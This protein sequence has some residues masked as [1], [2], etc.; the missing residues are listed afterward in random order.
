MS[1]NDEGRG[2]KPSQAGEGERRRGA[3]LR[4]APLRCA[5]G[6]STP[7]GPPPARLPVGKS[8]CR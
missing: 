2:G 5:P 7:Q 6:R 4:S 1:S 3:L 8:N